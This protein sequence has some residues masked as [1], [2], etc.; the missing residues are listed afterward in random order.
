LRRSPPPSTTLDDATSRN[1]PRNCA[2]C[3]ASRS[4][5]THRVLQDAYTAVAASEVAVIVT[6]IVRINR[7]G[8]VVGDHFGRHRDSKI[9]TRLPGLG[10]ILG[11]R[12]LGEFGEDPD[13]YSDGRHARTTPT[14]HRSS[15]I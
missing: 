5:G 15:R 3:C 9:Y 12:I 6:L 10:V 7:L 4:C 2:A 1:G 13:R 14:S 11:A 8:T